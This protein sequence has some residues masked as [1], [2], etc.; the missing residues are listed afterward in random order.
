MCTKRNPI[1]TDWTEMDCVATD[2]V[3]CV[4]CTVNQIV[5]NALVQTNWKLNPLRIP[6]SFHFLNLFRNTPKTH[7]IPAHCSISPL[8]IF[9]PLFVFGSTKTLPWIRISSQF[10]QMNN[11]HNEHRHIRLQRTVRIFRPTKQQKADEQTQMEREERQS[12]FVRPVLVHATRFWK[13]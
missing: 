13:F 10:P 2:L 11:A 8:I 7:K 4:H 6:C 3:R 12:Y 1:H 5:S 9:R